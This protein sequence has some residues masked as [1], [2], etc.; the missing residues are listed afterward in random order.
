M[1]RPKES[2]FL[3]HYMQWCSGLETNRNYDLWGG[4]WVLSNAVSRVVV[5]DRPGIPVFLNQYIIFVAESGITRKSTA[6][7]KAE[8]LLSQFQDPYRID[9]AG[10]V[11]AAQLQNALSKLPE[12]V[13]H[14]HIAI[15]ASELVTVLGRDGGTYGIPGLLTDLYDCPNLRTRIIG[16]VRL[17]IE[18]VYPTL[19]GASTPTW[20]AQAV[21]PAVIE[22][23]FTSR[24]LFVYEERPK[25][26]VP[27]PD[28]M[29]KLEMLMLEQLWDAR[30][31]AEKVQ[32]IQLNEKAKAFFTLW[33]VN[34]PTPPASD[35]FAMSF[36]AREDHHVL[37][38]AGLLAI[39]DGTFEVQVSQM[40]SAV[41]LIESVKR[42]AGDLFSISLHERRLLA[43]VDRLIAVLIKAGSHGMTKSEL[44]FK[45]REYMN[46][47]ERDML[48][49]LMHELDMVQKFE[50]RG[51]P[52]RPTYLYRG[53]TLLLDNEV[54]QQFTERV[55]ALL[56]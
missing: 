2:T 10:R 21:N 20:L 31:K 52:G 35:A 45:L 14:S 38:V 27:W 49:D 16:D 55:K 37:R 51:A 48:L 24:C 18:R 33:Y 13:P 50:L 25:K 40:K 46:V 43:G 47:A 54:R 7:S 11:T 39:N 53:T 44:V 22:G 30:N 23:G 41:A 56:A 17:V 34:R 28:P 5:V 1:F 26:M 29:P 9:I 19:L 3:H 4:L 12:D 6:V 42:G 36:F 8:Q 15:T 32:R